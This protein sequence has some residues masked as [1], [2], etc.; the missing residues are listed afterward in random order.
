MRTWT[1][2]E[3]ANSVS[4]APAGVS[5]L[6]LDRM[7]K[8]MILK[9]DQKRARLEVVTAGKTEERGTH[10]CKCLQRK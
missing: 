5:R 6:T 10:L 3:R 2:G 1:I 9:C 4:P 7:C 8:V